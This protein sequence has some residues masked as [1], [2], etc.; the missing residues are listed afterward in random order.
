MVVFEGAGMRYGGRG[1]EWA[2]KPSDLVFRET[3]HTVILGPN[4]AGKSTLLRLLLKLAQPTVGRISWSTALGTEIGFVPERPALLPELTVSEALSLWSARRPALD[5]GE[6]V[7]LLQLTNLANRRMRT[8]SKGETQ[9]VSLALGIVAGT[10]LLVLDEPFEGL[11]PLVR[12]VIRAGLLRRCREKR[13]GTVIATTHR[14]EEV[15]DPFQRVLVVHE[16]AALKDMTLPELTALFQAKLLVLPGTAS[17]EDVLRA[18]R[19]APPHNG[20]KAVRAIYRSEPA[21]LVG[22]FPSGLDSEGN[23]PQVDLESL[24]QLWILPDLEGEP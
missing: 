5:R 7:E 16:G 24:I 13:G 2:L 23:S 15:G 1:S 12:P 18:R 20:V 4:G 17:R 14:L 21:I 8:L 11:D 19:S 22:P 3:E 6:V 10:R 9:R